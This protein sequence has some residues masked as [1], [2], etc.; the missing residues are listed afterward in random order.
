MDENHTWTALRYTECNP[1]RAGMVQSPSEYA[2]SSAQA[3][4]GLRPSDPLV[5]LD[6]W[7]DRWNPD[8]WGE[9][10]AAASQREATEIRACT[11]N[12]RPLGSAEFVAGLEK[13]LQRLLH[14]NKGGRPKKQRAGEQ[15]NLVN[16]GS[17]PG[18]A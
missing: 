4:T 10:L 2:W 12:G 15:L 8:D 13:T 1:V 5:S 16:V 17:V 18:F 9:F 6:E 14:R 3:H 11:S 7:S